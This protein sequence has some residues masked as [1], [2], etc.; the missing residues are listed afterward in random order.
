MFHWSLGAASKPPLDPSI[1]AAL[2]CVPRRGGAE[3]DVIPVEEVLSYDRK[4]Q[5]RWL[6]RDAKIE[7]SVGRDLLILDLTDVASI[8]VDL[9]LSGQVQ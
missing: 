4:L 3:F 1:D 7:L 9:Q 2:D 6:P 8:R 5:G